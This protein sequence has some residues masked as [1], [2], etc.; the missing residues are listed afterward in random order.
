MASG[1]VAGKALEA[2]MI[3]HRTM[4]GMMAGSSQ[5][6]CESL[7]LKQVERLG[8]GFIGFSYRRG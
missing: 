2:W 1:S 4:R 3:E 5:T 8:N 7:T 6:G